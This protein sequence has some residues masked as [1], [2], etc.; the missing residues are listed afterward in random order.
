MKTVE[1]DAEQLGGERDA[2]GVVAGAGRDDAA[3][4]SPRR[5]SRAIR[6]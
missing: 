3:R 4:P 5:E 2:L 6:V 1:L